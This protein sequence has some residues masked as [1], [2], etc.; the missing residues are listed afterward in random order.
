MWKGIYIL[1]YTRCYVILIFFPMQ[2]NTFQEGEGKV[3]RGIIGSFIS[4]LVP[5]SFKLLRFLLVIIPI[6]L[7]SS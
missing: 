5:T 7:S 3:G 2:L 6:C 1:S 4:L